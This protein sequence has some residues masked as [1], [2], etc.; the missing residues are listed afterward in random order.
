MWGLQVPT[1]PHIV[2]Q[3]AFGWKGH[4]RNSPEGVHQQDGSERYVF[5]ICPQGTPFSLF[6]TRTSALHNIHILEKHKAKAGE[7]SSLKLTSFMQP[8]KT[9]APTCSDHHFHFLLSVLPL[10]ICFSVQHSSFVSWILCLLLKMTPIFLEIPAG[11]PSGVSSQRLSCLWLPYESSWREV[12]AGRLRER[13]IKVWSSRLLPLGR[14]LAMSLSR[15]KLRPS[16]FTMHR[17]WHGAFK[18]VVKLKSDY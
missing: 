12:L 17:I 6:L 13:W 5:L 16:Y 9:T 15:A 8:M 14:R 10:E 4:I 1:V 3:G 18:E 7:G 2:T 11:W